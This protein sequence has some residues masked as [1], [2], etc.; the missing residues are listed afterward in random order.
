[1][2]KWHPKTTEDKLLKEYWRNKGGRIYT[3]VRIGGEK[4]SKQWIIGSRNR[5]IDGICFQ[6]TNLPEKIVRFRKNKEEF[7]PLI[8]N[9]RVSLIEVKQ[10]LNRPVI[11]QTIVGLDMFEE[12][13][14]PAGV[15]G[16]ILCHV[17]DPALQWVCKK[18]GIEV[19]VI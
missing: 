16:L 2:T 6:N 14:Q 5:Y 19:V 1:M 18:R 13:Y 8:K 4:G 12:Q 3:E 15:K 9:S 10:R 17:D 7:L 11:G